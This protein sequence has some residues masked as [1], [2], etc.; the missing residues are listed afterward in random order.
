MHEKDGPA[1]LYD[2]DVPLELQLPTLGQ[3]TVEVAAGARE[4]VSP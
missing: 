3:D 4:S 2:I 1:S